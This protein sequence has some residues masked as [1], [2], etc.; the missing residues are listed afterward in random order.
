MQETDAER[1]LWLDWHMFCHLSVILG[2]NG[3]AK[4]SKLPLLKGSAGR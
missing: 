3:G 1:N 2:T 4:S